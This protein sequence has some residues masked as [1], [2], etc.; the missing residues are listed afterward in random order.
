M[1]AVAVLAEAD[2]AAGGVAAAGAAVA[3]AFT[4]GAAVAGAVAAGVALAAA[5]AVEAAFGATAGSAGFALA[6]AA[7]GALLALA[8]LAGVCAP[9]TAAIEINPAKAVN[10]KALL[11]RINTLSRL[12]ISS[13]S[14]GA[15]FGTKDSSCETEPQA[16]VRHLPLPEPSRQVGFSHPSRGVADDARAPG[17]DDPRGNHASAVASGSFANRAFRKL[18][19]D[20][21]PAARSRAGPALRSRRARLEH[22]CFG[23]A[24]DHPD[25]S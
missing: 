19:T 15:F 7:A 6:A 9:A 23:K 8:V 3:G 12:R 16:P 11:R 20:E 13:K 21:A 1:G 5:E 2:D 4:T 14:S 17:G 22:G 18:L 10:N 24:A 25:Q